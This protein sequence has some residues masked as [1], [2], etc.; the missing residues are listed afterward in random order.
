MAGRTTL[1]KLVDQLL[2]LYLI[3]DAIQYR[4]F[5]ETKVQKL[6]F[7][8]EWEMLDKHQ[9]GFNYNFIR[10]TFGAY[11]N[12][13]ESDIAFLLKENLV[14][15]LPNNIFQ[16]TKEGKMLLKDLSEIFEKN[17]NFVKKIREI[18]QKYAKLD[19]N[20][21][22]NIVYR[23]P[24]PYIKGKPLIGSLN[25]RTPLLKRIKSENASRIFQIS[26][27]E[28]ATLEIYFDSESFDS[29]IKASES[30]KKR[31]SLKFEGV[32]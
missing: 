2:L 22:V 32:F 4:W 24:H 26:P 14:R 3:Y 31:P 7:L 19:L 25:L 8:S 27:G 16:P 17:E 1:E 11:S 10:L 9:K 12:E 20:E 30:A 5:G 6:T 13:L 15:K 18:N 29:L 21:L 23:L 28:I